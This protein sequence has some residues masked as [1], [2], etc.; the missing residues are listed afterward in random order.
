MSL[1][2]SYFHPDPAAGQL[3]RD[4]VDE[5][6]PSCRLV[7]RLILADRFADLGEVDSEDDQRRAIRSMVT[8]IDRGLHFL[9]DNYC[10]EHRREL[11]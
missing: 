9:W 2:P 5:R 10:P 1:P 11:S 3:I 8:Y 4:I 7:L 6:C